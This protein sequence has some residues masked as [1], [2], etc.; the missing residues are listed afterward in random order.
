MTID[1]FTPF[2]H[3]GYPC[4]WLGNDGE[5]MMNKAAEQSGPPLSEERAMRRILQAALQE[6]AKDPALGA[7]TLPLLT[8][9]LNMR[10]LTILPTEDGV[11]AIGCE[12]K[13]AP[14]DAFS[15][16]MREPLTSI[17]SSLP[18]LTARLDDMDARYAEDIQL[19]CYRL[20]RV[21]NNIEHGSR[22]EK[23]LFDM[24]PV[25]AVD[26]ARSLC[27][28]VDS[29]CKDQG[30]PIEWELPEVPVPIRADPRLLS[31]A[32]L[33]MVR[34]SLQYTRD[35][36]HILIRLEQ[37]A[38]NLVLTIEDKGL[39]IKPEFIERVFE[40]YFSVDPYG[41]SNLRPGLGLGLSVVRETMTGFGGM[42]NIESKFGEG[43]RV[44]TS[45]PVHKNPGEVMRSDSAEYLL[46]RYSPV[47]VQ[48][49]GY[50]RLPGF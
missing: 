36:N 48:L 18:L 25:D 17:F 45:L 3:A 14:V 5:L 50:C 31:D 15:E 41:D 22:I 20:L 16:A 4:Y 19:N 37:V 35:G 12:E 1:C 47:Y 24:Q 44:Y 23:K 30:I 7:H 49:C 28:S 38:G 10:T 21:A 42:V 29:V 33:N 9:A 6:S 11:M 34:N 13:A 39:G 32:F 26:L 46:K 27:F 43:T 8:D 2:A 40:P